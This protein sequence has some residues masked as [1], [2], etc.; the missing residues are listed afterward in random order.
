MPTPRRPH[1]KV[2]SRVAVLIYDGL[3]AF[4]FAC[5]AEI[6]GM[7]RPELG[8]HWYRFETCAQQARA[9]RGQYG[10]QIKAD[11]GLERLATAGTVIV[12][13]WAGIDAPVP[14]R[15][16]EAL[17][18]AH[19]RGARLLSICSGS[20]VLA[21]TGLLDG[22]RATTHWRY[23]DA[24]QQRYP[25]IRVDAD[26]LYVDEGSLLTSAGSAAGLDLCLHLIRRDH[27][28]DIANQVA[29]RL[30]IPP[31]RDG[32]QAQFVKRPVQK[33]SHDKLARLMDAMRNRIDQ[34]LPIAELA[35]MAALSERTLI[36]RFKDATGTTPADWL[37]G[38]RL[39][40]ARELLE[41]S[42]HSIDSV[43]QLAGLGTAM[44]MRHH[45]RRRF[46]TSPSAYRRRFA[47]DAASQAHLR[48]VTS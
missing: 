12:P 3:C 1:A 41:V 13:G 20:F 44:T 28:P 29:R 45:F 14:Q 17:R 15:V 43:A 35:R 46:G 37:T 2:N 36:R 23:A 38:V 21:A 27:G 11:G 26:V 7:S 4:E 5:A 25:S 8:P 42:S 39:D 40:R 47:G 9:V 48:E 18:N 34:S 24:L 10:M 31:H 6:F 19:A 30:V 33:H 32:G 16:V 22:K